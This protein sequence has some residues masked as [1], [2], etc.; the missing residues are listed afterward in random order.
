MTDQQTSR[1]RRTLNTTRQVGAFIKR[2]YARAREAKASGKPVVWTFGLVPREIWTA[3]DVPVLSLEH[4]PV[5]LAA[6]QV[7][8]PYLDSAEQAGFARDLCPYHTAVLGCIESSRLDPEAEKLF[9]IPDMIVVSN[10][11]CVAQSKSFLHAV[12]KYDVPYFV[13]DAPLNLAA[14]DPPQ[15]ALDYHLE[16]LKG[17]LS[18][19]AEHGIETDDAQ[20]SETVRRSRDMARLWAE[21]DRFRM[22]RPAPMTMADGLTGMYLLTFCAG[23]AEALETV[24]QMRDEVAERAR[25]GV[26][27]VDDERLRLLF[28]GVPPWFNLGLINYPEKFGAVFVKSE[29]EYAMTGQTDINVLDPAYPLQSLAK[30][31]MIDMLCPTYGNRIDILRRAVREFSI[32][33]IVAAQKRGCRNLPGGFRLIKDMAS[34]EFGIPTSV[35]DLDGLDLRE[36]DDSRVKSSLDA[37]LGTLCARVGLGDG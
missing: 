7:I 12:E 26:G 31:A 22:L 25:N 34:A 3:L 21:I 28:L 37:F 11:P 29:I 36:Y 9:V 5:M 18:F 16:G 6:K 24:K 27:S 33:G 1:A 2:N 32:D 8:G 23:Q 14:H 17:L 20:L 15:R 10:M 4:I 35:I 19:L 30:K 13:L